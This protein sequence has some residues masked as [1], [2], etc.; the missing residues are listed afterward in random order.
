MVGSIDT[1][2][3]YRTPIVTERL[4]YGSNTSRHREFYT[5][6]HTVDPGIIF[7]IKNPEWSLGVLV[8]EPTPGR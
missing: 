2:N 6:G 8:F 5:T 7:T 4:W 3:G 1:G